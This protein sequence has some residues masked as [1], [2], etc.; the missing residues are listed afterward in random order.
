MNSL[1]RK[2]EHLEMQIISKMS[3]RIHKNIYNEY[4]GCEVHSYRDQFIQK[5]K[6]HLKEM[7]TIKNMDSPNK[8]FDEIENN[9]YKSQANNIDVNTNFSSERTSEKYKL[10]NE[11]LSCDP[12]NYP[13]IKEQFQG[14][15][16]KNHFG[17]KSHAEVIELS[18]EMEDKNHQYNRKIYYKIE[19]NMN[20]EKNE[21]NE[22]EKG[23]NDLYALE[24]NESL[25]YD[26]DDFD[27]NNQ[28]DSEPNDLLISEEG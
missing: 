13:N 21:K 20:K 10:N 2:I 1:N 12:L 26:E 24:G 16:S 27:S 22:G 28:F 19:S 14:Y 17:K 7:F 4:D 18:F 3:E 15:S 11:Y 6:T 23:G 5:G 9:V 8:L 25:F